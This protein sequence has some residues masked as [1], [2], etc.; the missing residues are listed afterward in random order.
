MQAILDGGSGSDA[1]IGLPRALSAVEAHG[2]T[3]ADLLAIQPTGGSGG[4]ASWTLTGDDGD[5]LI[6]GGP[7]TDT[8]GGGRGRDAIYAAGG[9]ADMITCGSGYD[10]VRADDQDTIAADCEVR[11]IT[12]ASVPAAVSSARRQAAALAAG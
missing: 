2:G 8:I 5:D 3:G 6:A 10:V 11:R 9:D 7:G 4:I 1:I 12:S